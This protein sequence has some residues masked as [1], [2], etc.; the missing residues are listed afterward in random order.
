MNPETSTWSAS[1]A[2]CTLR[3]DHKRGGWVSACHQRAPPSR[4]ELD[5]WVCRFELWSSRIFE[6]PGY[7]SPRVAY[8][9]SFCPFSPHPTTLRSPHKQFYLQPSRHTTPHHT[10]PRPCEMTRRPRTKRLLGICT[11]RGYQIALVL[12]WVF[13]ECFLGREMFA[14]VCSQR[15]RSFLHCA[16]EW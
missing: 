10:T 16:L 4:S 3:I 14:R 8:T 9:H 5:W 2:P 12:A 11:P 6:L 7:A 1:R 13:T 15:T